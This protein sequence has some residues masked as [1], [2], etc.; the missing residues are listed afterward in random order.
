MTTLEKARRR[1]VIARRVFEGVAVA[2]LLAIGV[3]ALS[4]FVLSR[5]DRNAIHGTCQ[6]WSDLSQIPLTAASSKTALTIVADARVSYQRQKCTPALPSPDP[7][8]VP[9]L[10]AH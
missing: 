7:R 3:V 8:V 4:G 1:Y 2:A 10:P 5:E 6:F 9:Y